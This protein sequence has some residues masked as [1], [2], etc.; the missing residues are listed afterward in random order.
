MLQ[1]ALITGVPGFA[2]S[3]LAEHLLA[4]G[5][6]VL[7]CSPDGRW[8]R[9]SPQSLRDSVELVA[10]DLANPQGIADPQGISRQGRRRIEEFRPD[11]IYHLAALSVPED[12]GKE[13][14]VAA[15]VAV[16]VDG[17]RRVMGLAASLPSRPRVLFTSSSHV[18]APVSPQ[19]DATAHSPK[20]DETAPLG[21]RWGYGRSKLAAEGEVRRAIQR[22]GCDAVIARS[23]QHTGP[24]QNPRMMLPEWICQFLAGGSEPVKVHTADAQIDLT[25]GRDVVRAYRSLVEH[26]RPGG[27]YNVGSGVS[28]RSGDVLEMLRQ[29]VDPQRPVVE[30]RPGRKQ[31]PIADISRLVGCTG[32]QPA[33]PLEKTVA[34]TLAWWRLYLAG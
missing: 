20:V 22:H 9:S 14:V 3:F 13:D 33:I 11:S 18:Y 23:F 31:D 28:R 6:A 34:D 4:C 8:E 7:G 12:C 1:R 29:M 2:G 10:W 32:W 30:L 26:G 17:T 24:R 27:V 15:A 16:N 21:P 5:D 25:D 19:L